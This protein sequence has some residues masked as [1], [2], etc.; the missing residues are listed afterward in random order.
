MSVRRR[1][2]SILCLVL[3][4]TCMALCSC[5]FVEYRKGL[6]LSP[7]SASEQQF[8]PDM[9]WYL[10][11]KN[12]PLFISVRPPASSRLVAI[13]PVFPVIPWI[14]G[15][16]QTI[17]NRHT[18]EIVNQ[19]VEVQI[20]FLG[21]HDKISHYIVTPRGVRLTIGGGASF[22][23]NYRCTIYSTPGRCDELTTGQLSI[24]VR[25]SVSWGPELS[26]TFKLLASELA[27]ADLDIGNIV[28]DG[29]SITVP[30][31]TI[32]PRRGFFSDVVP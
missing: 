8:I 22:P 25:P 29:M 18:Y 11:V 19:K 6:G 10:Y 24:W 32:R 21:V 13:G 1:L 23:E 20:N 4:T 15:I 9:G 7:E 17:R 12:P 3:P 26:L 5:S 2:S 31:I 16:I 27:G 14:P 28:F 30:K